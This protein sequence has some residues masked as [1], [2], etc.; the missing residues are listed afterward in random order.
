MMKGLKP[1]K[2]LDRIVLLVGLIFVALFTL[3]SN[4]VDDV[5]KTF[6][7]YIGMLAIILFILKITDLF[8]FKEGKSNSGCEGKG[9]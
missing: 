5:E 1:T 3:F 8:Y 2:K 7:L 6:T 4:R 9:D